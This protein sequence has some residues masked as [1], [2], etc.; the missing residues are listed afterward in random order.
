VN[1][2]ASLYQFER[3]SDSQRNFGIPAVD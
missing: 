3:G 2:L 1:H